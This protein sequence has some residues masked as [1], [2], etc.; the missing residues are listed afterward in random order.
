VPFAYGSGGGAGSYSLSCSSETVCA[1]GLPR[2][3]VT[4][5]A[6]VID[7][8]ANYF[9][10]PPQPKALSLAVSC[11]QTFCAAVDRSGLANTFRVSSP[12]TLPSDLPTAIL[13]YE[14]AMFAAPRRYPNVTAVAAS[15]TAGTVTEQGRCPSGTPAGGLDQSYRQTTHSLTEVAC[16]GHTRARVRRLPLSYLHT[17]LARYRN[18]RPLLAVLGDL[19]ARIGGLHDPHGTTTSV[20]ATS[21]E[22]VARYIEGP[23][24]Y[25]ETV[26]IK[27]HRHGL[28]VHR[29]F[30]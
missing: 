5:F 9:V 26:I 29:W 12:T 10:W 22:L 28:M 13:R 19:A 25:L 15:V 20:Y 4:T 24:G 14:D 18:Y 21:S 16:P 8:G 3:G 2:L 30:Y 27:R 7:P 6:G 17:V 11:I 23:H 1:F